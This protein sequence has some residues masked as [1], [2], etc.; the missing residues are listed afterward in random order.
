MAESPEVVLDAA[1][2]LTAVAR[3]ASPAALKLLSARQI[4]A[5]LGQCADDVSDPLQAMLRRPGGS[6]NRFRRGLS[7]LARS[8]GRRGGPGLGRAGRSERQE[9]Q[10]PGHGLAR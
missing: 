4:A 5:Y 2:E 9:R 7:G 8:R 6:E 10:R 1:I 3:S